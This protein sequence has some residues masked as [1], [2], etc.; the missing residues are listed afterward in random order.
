MFCKVITIIVYSFVPIDSEDL[1]SSLM[2]QPVPTHVPCFGSTLANVG[3]DKTV[4][5]GIVRL[6]RRGRLDVSEC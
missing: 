2:A 5:C 4:T 3:V 6:Y 1:L